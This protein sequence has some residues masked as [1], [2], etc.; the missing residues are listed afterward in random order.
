MR[1][2]LLAP[3]ALLS[4]HQLLTALLREKNVVRYTLDIGDAC[5]DDHNHFYGDTVSEVTGV[6]EGISIAWCDVLGAPQY[7][8]EVGCMMDGSDYSTHR[9][10]RRAAAF[11][12]ARD[13][14]ASAGTPDLVELV[15]E[16]VQYFLD[17]KFS[18]LDENGPVRLRISAETEG[19]FKDVRLR[20]LT[21]EEL[22]DLVSLIV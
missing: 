3:P 18:I 5:C 16:L 10:P 14:I 17:E 4:I 19:E 22:T 20:H 6:V 1:S 21:R 12:A 9:D 11:V 15:D 7:S 8:N 13:W 2:A